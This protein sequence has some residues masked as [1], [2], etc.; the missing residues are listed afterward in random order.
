MEQIEISRL[1]DIFHGGYMIAFLTVGL[2]FLLMTQYENKPRRLFLITAGLMLV[3]SFQAA[4][5]LI[6]SFA[7]RSTGSIYYLL[8][9]KGLSAVINLLVVPFCV[10][11]VMELTQYR[12]ATI[13][14]VFKLMAVPSVQAVC[15]YVQAFL[16]DD[17][18]LYTFIG[19]MVWIVWE[20]AYYAV[21]ALFYVR[22]YNVK[23]GDIYADVEGR[24]VRWLRT[25]L[26]ILISILIIYIVLMICVGGQI[27]NLA[28]IP[29]SLFFWMSLAWNVSCMRQVNVDVTEEILKD[30]D[31]AGDTFS[32]YNGK[33]EHKCTEELDRFMNELHDILLQDKLYAMPNLTRE[34]VALKMKTN[35]KYLINNVRAATGLTFSGYVTDV[36][37]EEVARILST[38]G[39]NVSESMYYCGFQSRTTFCRAFIKKFGCTPSEYKK[40]NYLRNNYCQCF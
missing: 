14:M 21:P 12:R 3:M 27:A 30:G 38:T 32:D 22:K 29:F 4:E 1:D 23:I 24:E 28:Y 40:Q 34:V 18:R 25:M 19:Y 36:R 16:Y 17:T 20:V 15:F 2:Y 8:Y 9:D 37:L 33:G 11:G 35:Y 26:F 5:Y 7:V 39:F 10:M 31:S 6:L 13:G